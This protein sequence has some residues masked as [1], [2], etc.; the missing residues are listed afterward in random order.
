MPSF[1]S[2]NQYGQNEEAL[3]LKS[4]GDGSA[5]AVQVGVGEEGLHHLVLD[6]SNERP[7]CFPVSGIF[8]QSI[9]LNTYFDSQVYPLLSALRSPKVCLSL[10]ALILKEKEIWAE[11]RIFL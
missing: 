11:M 9:V 4:D 1:T 8:S 6:G 10:F 2:L 5:K 7:S 3:R